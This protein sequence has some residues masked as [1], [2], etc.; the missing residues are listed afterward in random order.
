MRIFGLFPCLERDRRV[1][2]TPCHPMISLNPVVVQCQCPLWNLK[3]LFCHFVFIKLSSWEMMRRSYFHGQNF[4][5]NWTF[6]APTLLR[7]MWGCSGCSY[8]RQRDFQCVLLF[9]FLQTAVFI[10]N[11]QSVH[12][13]C[14]F[15]RCT[16]G[17]TP[18]PKSHRA[19]GTAVRSELG[20]ETFSSR[21]RKTS[22]AVWHH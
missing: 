4:T 3:G 21:W 13:W 11:T 2:W 6:I 15:A 10:A 12:V 7:S 5:L 17:T 9:S 8:R 22:E 19:G 16:A 1:N 14:I 18:W 20:Q